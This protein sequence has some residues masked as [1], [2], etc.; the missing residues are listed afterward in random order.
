MYFLSQADDFHKKANELLNW[1]GGAERQLRYHGALAD[2]EQGMMKQI[3]DHKVTEVLKTIV[4][5]V[6]VESTILFRIFWWCNHHHRCELNTADG[7]SSHF[8]VIQ[9][10]CASWLMSSN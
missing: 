9:C 1:L 6:V 7:V 10:D 4:I 8:H 2:D 3:E 5:C